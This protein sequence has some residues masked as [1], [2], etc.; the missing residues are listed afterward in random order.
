MANQNELDPEKYNSTVTVLANAV[1]L[2]SR[3]IKEIAGNDI[4]DTINNQTLT[5]G[6]MNQIALAKFQSNLNIS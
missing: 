1:E 4:S 2:V 3:V 5:L 6:E